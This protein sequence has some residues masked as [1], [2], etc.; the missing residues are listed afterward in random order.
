M[1][2]LVV[3]DLLAQS[4]HDESLRPQL[5]AYYRLASTQTTEHVLSELATFGMKPKVRPDLIPRIMLGLLDGLMLQ[6][7]VE[8]DVVDPDELV[9]SVELLAGALFEFQPPSGST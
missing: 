7:F 3:A 4:L 2:P 9:A 6:V 1:E 8:P 5:A